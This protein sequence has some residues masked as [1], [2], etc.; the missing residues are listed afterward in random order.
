MAATHQHEGHGHG[1]LARE[2]TQRRLLVAAGI[3]VT[4][5]VVEIVAGVL[6]HSLALLAD[7]VHMGADI[8][9]LGLAIFAVWFAGRSHTPRV[10]YG[11]HRVEILAALV[12]GLALWGAAAFI[13]IEAAGRFG[14]PPKVEAGPML[15]VAVLGLA[16]NIVSA[17]ILLGGGGQ[18][19]NLRAAT[20]HV[21]GDALGSVGAILAGVLMLAFSWYAA[22]AII[23]V[24]I[25]VI[26]GVLIL[27]ASTRLIRPAVHIL[28]EG[29]PR[30]VDMRKLESAIVATGGVDRVHDLHA[31]TLTSGYNAMTA[32][33]VL[34]PEVAASL[35]E[36]ILDRLR[37]MIPERFSVQHVTIQL[38]E[39]SSCCDV[40]HPLGSEEPGPAAREGGASTHR[41]R[42]RR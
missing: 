15:A 18:N 40:A 22:D 25:S 7:A 21:L 1:L 16:A 34:E 35:R 9:A 24:I 12:N 5:L 6:T 8:G 14:D 17:R 10:S 31:W 4:F 27:I 37:H 42:G 36:E 20:Y 41:S 19:L 30:D 29:T 23:S 28:L 26:I 13:F 11:Y 38:E 39:S 3:T 33:V 32:H 2:G